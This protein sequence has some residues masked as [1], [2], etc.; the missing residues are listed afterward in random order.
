MMFGTYRYC[1]A[2]L[3]VLTHLASWPGVGSYAVFGFYMLS[4]FLMSLILNERYGFSLQGLRGYA[5]NRALRI[6]PPY[7]FVLA[8]T[9][10]LVWALPNFAPQVR[11]SLILP[12]TW[13]AWAQQ[14]GIVGIDWQARSRLIPAS[15]SLY[16]ELVYYVAMA[17][18]LARNRTIVLLWLGA[19][20][21]YTLWLL[22]SGA[23]WQLRY[24]PVLAASLPFSLGATI[25]CYRD[26]LP[27]ISPRLGPI[28]V[29][30]FVAHAL[31]A[32]FVYSASA[33]RS[34]G[35]YL[36]LAIAVI[37]QLALLNAGRGNVSRRFRDLDRLLGDLSYPVFL[38]HVLAAVVVMRAM[39]SDPGSFGIFWFL[40]SVV[41]ANVIAYA[42]HVL[43]ESPINRVRDRVRSGTTD[44]VK[45]AA[46]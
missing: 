42:L 20:V 8:A 24:Y 38:C 7:L 39:S 35:F 29:A 19:S 13:L 10:V 22:V 27:R 32:R 26:R 23:E 14:I 17:L 12:D 28:L 18:V 33:L 25:Y 4:G 9:A 36:S 34:W 6:Y 45:D 5:A 44:S 1:L 11:G 30:I 37:T 41:L 15:W 46:L 16:A 40:A 43:V 21:A 31:C 2:H 3:V